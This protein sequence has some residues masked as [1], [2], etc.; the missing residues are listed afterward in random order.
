MIDEVNN[1]I[2]KVKISKTMNYDFESTYTQTLK[3]EQ[4]IVLDL[5]GKITVEILKYIY[6]KI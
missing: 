3:T 1:E 5:R 4:R 2:N 6:F